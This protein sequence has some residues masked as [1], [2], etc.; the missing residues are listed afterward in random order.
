[1]EAVLGDENQPWQS[2]SAEFVGISSTSEPA[3]LHWAQG[4]TAPC[5]GKAR[6]QEEM[7]LFIA[8]EVLKNLYHL[9]PGIQ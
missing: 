8:I 1:M 4:V 3:S 9:D 2:S 7:I 5:L 6:V